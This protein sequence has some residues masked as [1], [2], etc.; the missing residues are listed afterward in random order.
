MAS[1]VIK[2]LHHLQRGK[3]NLEVFLIGCKNDRAKRKFSQY[4]NK[5]DWIIK[6]LKTEPGITRE[7]SD[8][9]DLEFNSDVFLIDAVN[10]KLL[11]LTP[12][13]RDILENIL[14]EIIKGEQI[15]IE[16]IGKPKT[17]E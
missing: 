7:L 17:H 12:Y 1:E 11:L 4:I 10:E 16:Y 9:I 3:L 13:E 6:D 2:F 8:A 5:I 15:K 14:D